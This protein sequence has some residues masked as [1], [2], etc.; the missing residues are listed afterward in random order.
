MLG[1]ML[2][3]M[4]TRKERQ[5]RFSLHSFRGLQGGILR[6][7]QGRIQLEKGRLRDQLKCRFF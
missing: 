6:N 5:Y 3:Q 1:K 7:L 4:T 2:L